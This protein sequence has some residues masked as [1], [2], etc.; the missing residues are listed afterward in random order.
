MKDEEEKSERLLTP[1]GIVMKNGN[2]D[3]LDRDKFLF[4]VSENRH[5]FQKRG[6]M[7]EEE[8]ILEYKLYLSKSYAMRYHN[9]NERI[10]W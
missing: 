10:P 4:W 9:L 1:Y 3:F 7:F 5:K 8:W 6:D 2:L